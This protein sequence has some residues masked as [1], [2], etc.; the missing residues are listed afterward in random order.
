MRVIGGDTTGPHVTYAVE[1]FAFLGIDASSAAMAASSRL[2]DKRWTVFRRYSA[3]SRLHRFLVSKFNDLK[4]IK[5]PPKRLFGVRD[6]RFIKRRASD[7]NRYIQAVVGRGIVFQSP[8]LAKF[9]EVPDSILCVASNP[10]VDVSLRWFGEEISSC[11]YAHTLL[12][13]ALPA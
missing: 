3:F 4:I 8:E 7:L 11:N 6:S 13:T 10:D 12:A 1:V 2:P 9:L 5:L